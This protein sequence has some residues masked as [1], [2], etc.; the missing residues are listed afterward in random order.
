MQQS[1]FVFPKLNLLIVK[2]IISFLPQHRILAVF[3]KLNKAANVCAYDC[4]FWRQ[5]DLGALNCFS[6]DWY[7]YAAN[8][9]HKLEKPQELYSLNLRALGVD[10]AMSLSFPE[11]ALSA[12]S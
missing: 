11:E 3:A 7:D 2:T 12:V 1:R 10:D 9:L 4:H 6:H 5:L 8:F